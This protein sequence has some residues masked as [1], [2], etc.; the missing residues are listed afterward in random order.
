[1]FPCKRF[2]LDFDPRDRDRDDDKRDVEA[3]WVELDGAAGPDRDADDP[4][5]L[6]DRDRDRDGRDRD[7]DSRDIFLD[8]IELPRGLDREVLLD[9]EERYEL[10]GSDSR[11]IA[12]VGAFRVVAERDLQGRAR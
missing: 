1:M 12:A 9:G 7:I 2:H 6:G 11:T 4:R 3:R 5:D 8:G 10:N